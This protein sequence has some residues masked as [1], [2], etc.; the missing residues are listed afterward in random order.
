ML[1][2]RLRKLDKNAKA[3]FEVE[4]LIEEFET[5]CHLSVG[6]DAK[7]SE[8]WEGVAIMKKLRI[9]EILKGQNK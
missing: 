9:E 8:Y 2:V 1:S 5:A 7:R 3:Q 4:K 6:P